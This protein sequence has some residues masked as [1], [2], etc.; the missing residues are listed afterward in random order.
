MAYSGLLLFSCQVLSDSWGPLWTVA[1]QVPLYMEI[2]RQ[3]YQS[4][5]CHFLL[6]GTFLTEIKPVLKG[7]FFTSEPP[8]K[9]YLGLGHFLIFFFPKN[10]TGASN[11]DL[12]SLSEKLRFLYLFL[13]QVFQSQVSNRGRKKLFYFSQAQFQVTR[14]TDSK[15]HAHSLPLEGKLMRVI[16]FMCFIVKIRWSHLA[17]LFSLLYLNILISILH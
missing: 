2:P 4:M 6:K 1:H 7:K 16:K 13:E 9:L 8:G 3:E 14:L 11:M 5:G 17:L 12:L 15:L 10:G